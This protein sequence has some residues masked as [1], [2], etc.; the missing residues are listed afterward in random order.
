MPDPITTTALAASSAKEVLEAAAQAEKFLDKLAGDTGGLSNTIRGDKRQIKR[1]LKQVELLQRTEEE[2]RSQGIN[3]RIIKWNV[4]FPLLDA[5]TLEDD[6]GMSDRWAALLAN[7]A[8]PQAD[9][10]PPSFPRILSELTPQEA[11]LLDAYDRDAGS[12]DAGTFGGPSLVTPGLTTRAAKSRD[13]EY[14]AL[15]NLMRNR[16]IKPVEREFGIGDESGT[17]LMDSRDDLEITALGA[18]FVRACHR[19]ADRASG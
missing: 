10:I 3:P 19:K 12:E 16:L 7:A 5:A 1:A 6:P 17:Y 15:D 8:D 18:A 2:L 4:V 14:V 11:Q 9:E 13:P